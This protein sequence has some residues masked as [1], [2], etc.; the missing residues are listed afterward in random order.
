MD[1][2]LKCCFLI[3]LYILRKIY[4]PFG[5]S[6]RQMAISSLKEKKHPKLEKKTCNWLQTRGNASYTWLSHASVRPLQ[7]SLPWGFPEAKKN[8][9]K[10]NKSDKEL[11]TTFL[12][13][14]LVIFPPRGSNLIEKSTKLLS[15]MHHTSRHITQLASSSAVLYS[16]NGC[17]GLFFYALIWLQAVVIFL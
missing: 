5:N 8:S 6:G 10:E 11:K 14:K 9:P 16:F 12:Q 17:T 13:E 15:L 1:H 2:L 7:L 4:L 3:L